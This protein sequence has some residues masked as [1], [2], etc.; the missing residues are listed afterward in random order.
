V[1][2][3]FTAGGVDGGA[4]L[5]ALLAGALVEGGALVTELPGATAAPVTPLPH[6]ESVAASA[7]VTTREYAR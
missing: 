1:V 6:E 3:F 4:V 2:D 7:N 5:G